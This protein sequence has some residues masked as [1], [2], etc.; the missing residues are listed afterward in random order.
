MRYECCKECRHKKTCISMYL[1]I[2]TFALILVAF[3]GIISNMYSNE[4][5]VNSMQAPSEGYS[6][7]KALSGAAFVVLISSMILHSCR[8]HFRK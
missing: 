6:I 2:C 4:F 8:N 1:L 7:L 5:I 3:L